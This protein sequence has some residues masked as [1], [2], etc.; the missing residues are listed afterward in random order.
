MIHSFGARNYFSFAEGM[1]VSFEL[2]S[3]V[4]KEFSRGLKAST[5]LGVKGANGSGKTNVLKAL[6][7]LADFITDSFSHDEKEPIKVENFFRND[8]PTDFYVNFE[9]AATKYYYELT[10]D[11]DRVMREALYKKV[12]RKTLVFERK[13]NEVVRRPVEH[14][15][16]DIIELKSTASLVSTMHKYKLK[17]ATKDLG[18][19][20]EFFY[21]IWGNVTSSGPVSDE[22]LFSRLT[23]TEF[24]ASAPEALAFAKK[25]I[26][27]SDL[28]IVDIILHKNENAKGDI[29][30]FPLFVHDVKGEQRV[31]SSYQESSG[32]MALYRKLGV[33]WCALHEGGVLI[34]DEFDVN[35]HPM[36]LPQMISLFE[37][38][39]VNIG[40]AQFIFTAHNADIIDELGKYRTILVVKEDNESFC[41][42]IDQIPGDIIRNDRSIA[43]LYRE[44]KLGGVPKL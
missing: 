25:I 27:Q 22:K 2:N 32:T 16:L 9:L 39:E 7:F 26:C 18:E 44:G 42:R 4:P 30:H 34:M 40:N 43:A 33:Y 15:E 20:W 41:Y 3:K 8:K 36:L 11:K 13:N 5:V 1:E 24:Y 19:I 12:Q 21:R 10:L 37:D 14:T 6:A 29:E 35:C 23:A 31:L 38:P 17:S 28:G